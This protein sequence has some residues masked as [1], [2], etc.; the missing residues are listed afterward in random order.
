[1]AYARRVI[2]GYPLILQDTLSE[3]PVRQIADNIV[4]WTISVLSDVS[5]SRWHC[6]QYMVVIDLISTSNFCWSLEASLADSMRLTTALLVSRMAAMAPMML[7]GSAI[8]LRDR[9]RLFRRRRVSPGTIL[10]EHEDNVP[11]FAQAVAA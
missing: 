3:T 4:L 8:S 9:A 1:M 10:F 7:I 5:S 2:L 11:D 6:I